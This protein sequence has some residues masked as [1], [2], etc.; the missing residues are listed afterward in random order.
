MSEKKNIEVLS[1]EKRTFPPSKKASEHAHVKSIAEY[2]KL[3]KQSVKEPEK[4]WGEQ[5]E[6]NLTWYKKWDKVLDYDFHKPSIKWFTG[7]KLNVSVNCL[8]RHITTATRNKAALIWEADGGDYRTYTYQQMY[9]EV[10][11]FANVLKKKGIR[12]GDRVT[13]YLPM[14]PELPIAMLACARIGAVHSVV[15]GGFSAESLRDRINDAQAVALITADGNPV[16]RANGIFQIK[17]EADPHFD[18]RALFA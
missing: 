4:F 12:K 6:K 9:Y 17:G 15:F 16:V 14:I 18:I 13:I 8:D 3:Y 11:K 5:A 1:T 7:G 2:E 10:N